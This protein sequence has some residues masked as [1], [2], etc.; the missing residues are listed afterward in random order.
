MIVVLVFHDMEQRVLTQNIII[1]SSQFI[2]CIRPTVLNITLKIP[3]CKYKI[4]AIKKTQ[5]FTEHKIRAVTAH[6]VPRADF[7]HSPLASLAVRL[8]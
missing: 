6:G 4:L 1:N 2:I 7:L 5:H 3:Q 8:T